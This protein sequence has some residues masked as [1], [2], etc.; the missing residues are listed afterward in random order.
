MMDFDFNIDMSEVDKTVEQ[1]EDRLPLNSRGLLK[2]VGAVIM[3]GS[4]ERTPVDTGNLQ[5]S[6]DM[7]PELL[8]DESVTIVAGGG[9][10]DYGIK[11]H[12]DLEVHHDV[13]QAKFMQASVI[14][15][16]PPAVHAAAGMLLG[17]A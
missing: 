14:E 3:E 13:G 7:P 11:V 8:T 9:E 10:A 17:G 16:G 2:T 15:D 12:E 4:A 6:H 5:G 1:Y